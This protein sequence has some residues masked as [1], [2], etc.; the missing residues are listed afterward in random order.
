MVNKKNNPNQ[1]FLDELKKQ[2]TKKLFPISKDFWNTQ[3]LL[4]CN[5]CNSNFS[6]IINLSFTTISKITEV[7]TKCPICEENN[8][9]YL[10]GIDYISKGFIRQIFSDFRKF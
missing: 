10:G 7:K 8:Y 3:L 6:Y 5:K 4:K 9:Q 2:L 1:L